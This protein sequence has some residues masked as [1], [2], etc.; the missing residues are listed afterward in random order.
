MAQEQGG[1]QKTFPT[2]GIVPLFLLHLSHNKKTPRPP[3]HS[4]PRSGKAT[5]FALPSPPCLQTPRA[6]APV[7]LRSRKNLQ[8]AF[9]VCTISTL[10]N[11]A[12]LLYAKCKAFIA[13]Q[14]CRGRDSPRY[15]NDQHNEAYLLYTKFKTFITRQCRR[16]RGS[17]KYQN[18]QH[19]EPIFYM[20]KVKA[21]I[22]RQ[23]FNHR[24]KKHTHTT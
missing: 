14:C 12:H 5:H 19:N 20:Q 24:H 9:Q 23:L 4:V 11:E 16:G 21:L 22:T 18:D 6:T 15:Q 17:P 8:V 10:H 7:R 13:R 1:P 2:A 3:A